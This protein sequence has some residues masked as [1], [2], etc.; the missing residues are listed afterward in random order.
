M[1]VACL[2]A[3]AVLGLSVG[4]SEA[5]PPSHCTGGGLRR[6]L[7]SFVSAYDRGDTQMLDSLFAE[8][9]DFEWYSTNGPGERL[10]RQARQRGSLI[11][12]FEARHARHDRLAW[13]SFGFNGN[14]PRYGNFEFAMWRA[15][16]GFNHGGRFPVRGKGAAIC[17][18]D[19]TRFIVLSFGVPPLRRPS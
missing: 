14:S 13:R 1:R 9:P 16:A 15:T 7:A 12:Y 8:E 3:L 11:P 2:A 17:G 5:S 18:R 10:G 19:S 4:T 6:A